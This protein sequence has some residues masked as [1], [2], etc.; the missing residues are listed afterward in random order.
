VPQKET[1]TRAV[2]A[3]AV[4]ALTRMVLG[5][6]LLADPTLIVLA[7]GLAGARAALTEPLTAE[8]IAPGIF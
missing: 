7:G 4:V 2:L 5:V 1:I 6:V 8:L 3:D